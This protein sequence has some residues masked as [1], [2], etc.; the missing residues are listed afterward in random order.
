MNAQIYLWLFLCGNEMCVR[1]QLERMSSLPA[2]KYTNIH[3]AVRPHRRIFKS[4]ELFYNYKTWSISWALSSFKSQFQRI[5]RTN[6]YTCTSI[7]ADV[8]SIFTPTR[9]AAAAAVAATT[10]KSHV[11]TLNSQPA[12]TTT[13]QRN[14]IF[15][16][17]T[18]KKD[19]FCAVSIWYDVSKLYRTSRQLSSG[20]RRDLLFCVRI[21]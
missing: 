12:T 21:P 9:A 2:Q 13:T 20:W 4:T 3:I 18:G 11:Q 5:I 14:N 16:C 6:V 8:H 7:C 1:C 17:S 10:K 15:K 19:T